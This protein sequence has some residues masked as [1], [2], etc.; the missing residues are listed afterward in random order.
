MTQWMD[1]AWSHVGLR[2]TAGK[3]A[4]PEIVAMF[5]KAGHGEVVSDEVPWCAAFVGACLK[6]VGLSNTGSL[7]ARSYATYGTRCDLKV[8]AIAVLKRGAPPSGHVGFVTGWG[9]GTVR[10]LGGNQGNAVCEASFPL[11]DLIDVRWP[12]VKAGV[13]EVAAQAAKPLAKSRT[14]WSIFAGGS[15]LTWLGDIVNQG[16][17]IVTHAGTQ[18]ASLGPGREMLAMIGGNGSTI[19]WAIGIGC[20]VSAACARIDDS[21]KAAP[22]PE[23]E[24]S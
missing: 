2:E 18:F 21:N 14:L 5:A 11:A 19:A 9:D 6:D 8:G 13:T 20:L 7:M 17:E 1:R 23:G 10:L 3:S 4:T 16:M 15:F 22:K 12:P 24:P